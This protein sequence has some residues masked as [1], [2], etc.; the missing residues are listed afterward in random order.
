MK[1]WLV[2]F[3]SSRFQRGIFY[4]WAV[5]ALHSWRWVME[6]VS[7]NLG[8]SSG[9]C[10]VWVRETRSSWVRLTRG[11]TIGSR[12]TQEIFTHSRESSTRLIIYSFLAGRYILAGVLTSGS[13]WTRAADAAGS[14]KLEN[15]KRLSESSWRLRQYLNS[16]GSGGMITLEGFLP[17]ASVWIS[18]LLRP[19]CANSAETSQEVGRNINGKCHQLCVAAKNWFTILTVFVLSFAMRDLNC[20]SH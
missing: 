1:W 7:T 18:Q 17:P 9:C 2:F 8:C 6:S 5:C 12:S 19:P 4:L 10:G 11:K 13:L 16:S 20:C 3:L 14:S 15:S